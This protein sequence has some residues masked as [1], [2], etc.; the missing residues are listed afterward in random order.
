MTP[1]ERRERDIEEIKKRINAELALTPE[2][3]RHPIVHKT[4][5]DIRSHEC[6]SFYI[7]KLRKYWGVAHDTR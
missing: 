2:M 6:F 4:A 7:N 3:F 1:D 5:T